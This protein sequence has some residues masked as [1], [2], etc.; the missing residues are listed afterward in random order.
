MSFTEAIGSVFS[1]YVDFDGRAHRSEYW[2]FVLFSLL[3]NLPLEY[4]SRSSRIAAW[5]AVLFSLATFL[6]GLAVEIR[7]LHDIE[8]SGWNI[9]LILIP[10]VGAIILFVFLCREG[11]RGDNM[12]GPD[13]TRF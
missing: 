2:Y 12:Y 11:D 13:P 7:R 5:L 3:I 10:L 1:K 4:L 9:F 6:P 8:K